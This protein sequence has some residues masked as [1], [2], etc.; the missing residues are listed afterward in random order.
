MTVIVSGLPPAVALLGFVGVV[1]VVAMAATLLSALSTVAASWS[2]YAGF[3]LEPREFSARSGGDALVL[4]LVCMTAY[5]FA[6]LI[7]SVRRRDEDALQRIPRQ[8]RRETVG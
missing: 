5:G 3:L 8:C 4:L 1:D 2:L 6:S 7:R